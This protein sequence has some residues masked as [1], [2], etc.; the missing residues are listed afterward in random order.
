MRILS[1]VSFFLVIIGAI[2]WLLVG[3]TKFDLV[4]WV[5][6][7][8]SWLGRTVYSLVGAAGVTELVNYFTNMMPSRIMPIA[9]PAAG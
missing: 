8:N 5:F 3:T 2:N 9:P 4:R 7:R 6:G 1:I